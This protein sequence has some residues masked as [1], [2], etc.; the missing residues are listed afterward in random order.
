M[1]NF[2]RRIRKKMADNNKP[3]MYMRYAIGEI[4][5]VVIGILIALQI[6]NWNEVRKDRATEQE[7]LKSLKIDFSETK[8]RLKETMKLQNTVISHSTRLLTLFETDHLL[9]KKD[10]IPE[11]V[12]FGALS[13]WRAEPVT[14]TFDAMV[15]TGNIDLLKNKKLRRY[16]SEF[17]AEIKSGFEDHEY[18]IDL[19]T[20]LTIEQS[21]Y[22]F[23]LLHDG[24]RKESGLAEIKDSDEK[25]KNLV[26]CLNA[27]KN[28]ERFFG[29]LASK[30]AMERNRLERQE[31]M[32]LFA[33]N[34]LTIID[35]EL[36][37]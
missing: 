34:I 21:A 7:L 26:D 1:I 36:K 15:S 8:T 27:L 11:F 14:G 25:N 37:K 5:L 19:L 20:Q 33:D 24:Y 30:L 4:V 29:F 35:T 16:L 10:S 32:M 6:N 13:W 18:S 12:L 3:M 22:P 28:N 31:K 17:D 23:N 9:D 2:F